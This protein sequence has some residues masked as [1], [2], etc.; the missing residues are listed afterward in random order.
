M[1]SIRRLLW[2]LQLQTTVEKKKSAWKIKREKYKKTKL[3]VADGKQRNKG[4]GGNV[5]IKLLGF[6]NK[7]FIGSQVAKCTIVKATIDKY[8][9]YLITCII[10]TLL[11]AGSMTQ[12]LDCY[13]QFHVKDQAH[14]VTN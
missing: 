11:I 8:A 6:G 5:F 3:I 9:S 10:F 4:G 2:L 13:G 12:L 1:S 7:I 14:A